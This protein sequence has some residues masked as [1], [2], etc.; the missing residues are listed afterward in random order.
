M[1]EVTSAILF[2]SEMNEWINICITVNPYEDFTKVQEIAE[3]AYEEWFETDSC[4]CIGDYIKRKLDE[5]ECSYE[6]YL[7]NFNEDEEET[8]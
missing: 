6:M 5:S 8:E 2:R 4:E 1:S 7:G 3:K